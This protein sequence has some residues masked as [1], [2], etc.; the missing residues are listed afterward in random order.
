MSI[1][2]LA[3]FG[4][5]VSDLPAWKTYLEN[6]LGMMCVDE[7]ENE[8]RFRMDSYGWRI[9]CEKGD[10]DDL[11]FIGLEIETAEAFE[12]FK[13]NLAAKGVTFTPGGDDLKTRRGVR[14]LICLTDPT[15]L[16]VEVFVGA[17]Q[18]T[19]PPF[20]SPAGVSSFLTGEQ[21]AGHFALATDNL[22]AT[23]RFYADILGFRMSDTIGMPLGPDFTL[24]LEF[25]HC[26]PRHHTLAIADIPAGKRIHHFMVEMSSMDDVGYAMD[27]MEACRVKQTMTLGKHSNDQMI[28]FYASTP[29]GFDVE[30]GCAGIPV[31]DENWR[32]THHN[33]ISMWGH[34]PVL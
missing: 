18:K 32:V 31:H 12:L 19:Q 33:V 29:S 21:G 30:V 8:L 13:A 9:A 26:N 24:Y 4:F 7:G 27:R 14:D 28:S 1:S 3:Y 10:A 2:N 22:E 23:R 17:T 11:S 5:E 6:F 34:K 16:Q 20:I 15:G 25:Y